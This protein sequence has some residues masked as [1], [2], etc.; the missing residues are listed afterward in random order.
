[1]YVAGV[2]G[3][4]EDIKVAF[5]LP[6]VGFIVFSIITKLTPH[7]K[8]NALMQRLSLIFVI[9]LF[10]VGLNTLMFQD[11][12]ALAALWEENPVFYSLVY[13]IGIV[14]IIAGVAS[15]VY[16]KLRP[17]LWHRKEADSE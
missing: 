15:L 11:R 4:I 1:M 16:W 14:L 12:F 17:Q 7:S 13:C 10:A 9:L 8:V 6:V 2:D 3:L 5:V